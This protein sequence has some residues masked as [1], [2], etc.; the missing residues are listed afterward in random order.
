MK[1]LL[2]AIPQ[3]GWLSDSAEAALPAELEDWQ[4]QRI[5][6]ASSLA[7]FDLLVVDV[8][9]FSSPRTALRYGQQTELPILYRCD[10]EG[11]PHVTAALLDKDDVCL[12]DT[13]SVLL[14]TRLAKLHWG[15]RKLVDPLTGMQRRESIDQYLR[16]WAMKN[17]RGDPIS[18]L[19]ADVDDFKGFNDR[20]G[21]DLGDQCL[22]QYGHLCRQVLHR[23]AVI[24]RMGGQEF[25]AIFPAE[26]DVAIEAAQRL[27]EASRHTPRSA[28][29]LP[30]LSIGIADRNDVTAIDQL[31]ETA[32]EALYAAK[33]HGRNQMCLYRQLT[34]QSMQEGQ[35]PDLIALENRSRVMGQRMTNF[36]TM[37][38][39]RILEELRAEAETDGLTQC[40]TRR[41]LDRRLHVQ[42][43]DHRRRKAPLSI[44][45]VDLDHFGT[46]NKRHGWPTGD[47][48]L[49]GI[50]ETLRAQV[51]QGSDWVGRYGGEEFC[52][53]FPETELD[54]A[55]SVC[56]RL[57]SLVAQTPIT[58]TTGEPLRV[59]L[60]IG[61]IRCGP[62]DDS[63]DAAIERLSKITL[64]AKQQGRDRVCHQA[65]P[66]DRRRPEPD[67]E[68]AF[69]LQPKTQPMPPPPQMKR[70][71]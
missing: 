14:A 44:A 55:V 62:D 43:Y 28:V 37:R 42:F 20:H 25:A 56:E 70:T 23:A 16:G 6:P 50:S 12:L 48:V 54:D 47:S 17:R 71:G 60:S 24:A 35:T 53:V 36:I 52:L 8:A 31:Y 46:F 64:Q 18:F 41:Y 4:L 7:P 49:R 13:P 32:D 5:D 39:R 34:T 2:A 57:R 61:V 59:T 45:L 21:R 3:V 40:Y 22:Q 68:R 63:P 29:P 69:E 66:H 1:A 9:A 51:R 58:S 27:R 67:N 19:L 38:S 10:R 65:A 30:S 26:I 33:A 15:Q 11:L